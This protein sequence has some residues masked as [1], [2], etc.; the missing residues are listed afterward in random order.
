M[1]RNSKPPK[2]NTMEDA[3]TVGLAAGV[4]HYLEPE[5]QRLSLR[6]EEVRSLVE[7]MA[8]AIARAL[9]DLKPQIAAILRAQQPNEGLLRSIAQMIPP[10]MTPALRQVAQS[11][12]TR[13]VE[14]NLER[15][16]SEIQARPQVWNFEIVRDEH[17]KLI[18][19]VVATAAQPEEI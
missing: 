8:P 18:T 10:D 14:A 11:A 19:D 1:A 6:T 7:A 13:T 4:A 3:T 15:L 5:F 12:N 2:V 17:T 9:G 16:T